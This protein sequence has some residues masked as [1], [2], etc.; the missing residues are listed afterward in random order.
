VLKISADL[1]LYDSEFQTEG[2]LTLNFLNFLSEFVY[3]RVLIFEAKYYVKVE[4]I[5]GLQLRRSLLLDAKT[6][7]TS[8]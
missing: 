4:N 2:A 7:K 1:Q 5:Y 8:K 6:S 3:Y